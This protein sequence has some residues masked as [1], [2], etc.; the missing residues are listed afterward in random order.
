MPGS[1]GDTDACQ[2]EAAR[3][4]ARLAKSH[5]EAGA[6]GVLG[7]VECLSASFGLDSVFLSPAI[8]AFRNLSIHPMNHGTIARY[9][10]KVLWRHAILSQFESAVIFGSED[11]FTAAD[12]AATVANLLRSKNPVVRTF[13]YH[14]QVLPRVNLT[15]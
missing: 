3:I 8:T 10:A 2:V 11:A 9:A 1:S 4:V 13:F 14:V 6:L 12:A 15:G 5:P 7:C